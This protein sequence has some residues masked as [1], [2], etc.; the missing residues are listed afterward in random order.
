MP[1][2][3]KL[4]YYWFTPMR[5]GSR[6]CSHILRYFGF[7]N[8]GHQLKIHEERKHFS[9]ILNVR[10][11]FTRLVSLYNLN[12]LWEQCANDKFEEWAKNY[13]TA[14][15]PKLEFQIFLRELLNERWQ[16]KLQLVKLESFQSDLMKIPFVHSEYENLKEVIENN[17]EENKYINEFDSR[18]IT[19][20]PW[21]EFY[22]QELINFVY[23][24]LKYQFDFFSY[25]PDYWIDG[26]P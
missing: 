3:D 16:S 23:E 26:N 5:T 21:Q 9:I 15:Y 1:H 6:S 4:Q 25:N 2:S 20:K 12:C 17:I 19:K 22:N 8:L 7:E 18:L 14:W 11:P 13:L 24:N 10:H